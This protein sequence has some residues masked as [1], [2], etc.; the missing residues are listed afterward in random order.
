[1][2]ISSVS[3]HQG[4][5]TAD[6]V[7]VPVW[8]D[9]KKPEI[10]CAVKEFES[11]V[12]FPLSSGDFHGK[13]GECLL[14]YL[15]QGKE[16]RVLLLGLGGKKACLPDTLRRAYASAVKAMRAKKLKSA[17]FLLPEI[18]LIGWEISCQAIIEGVL[19]TSYS[20]D[21]LKGESN[22]EEKHASLERSCFCG[23]DKADHTLLKKTETVIRSV[24]FVRDLV[25]GNADDI[26]VDAFKKIA[27]DFEKEYS[28][29]KTTILDKKG[30]EKEKMGLILAVGRASTREPALI[31][32]EYTGNPHSK[33]KVAII[34]KG[35]TFDTG[36][37]NIK[38]AGTGL[39][40]M[41]CDMA[42]AGV[43]L[44]IIQAAAELKLKVN[45]ISVLPVTENAIGP[46]SYK[47]GDVY[48][49]HSGRTV[50]IS[51]T[52]AEGRLV[53]ADAIS[54]LQD[55]Y[56]PSQ[57]IDFATL[58]GGVIV[59]LGEEATG[60]F[61]NNDAL[62][63]QLEKAGERTHERLWRLP[64]YP[65]YK[66]YLKSSIADIKNSGSRK[67]SAGSGATFIQ[68]FVKKTIPWA[69]LD[70]A[71]TAYLSELKPYHSTPATG[72]GIRLLVDF[73]EHLDVS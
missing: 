28:Q 13:E 69:H 18:D 55:N 3:T 46:A 42:G 19:L 15:P 51:N 44:G 29:V 71:G 1:M 32:L 52:D 8:Q 72:V 25:N 54:Y 66:D 23:L 48:R 57:M 49:S 14:L 33:E 6:V 58:T 26:H 5:K 53:L 50:E 37:L 11:V 4:R 59:A 43:A 40:S 67:A 35:I 62:A 31:I 20:F 38:V 7:V 30:L 56:E 47:P 70:I 34:G 68:Q 64:L 45:L 27:K 16:K 73:L 24:N 10:A 41:K 65:E 39:E 63:K 21:R 12:K 22:E 36:G 2:Q 9:K 17:N 61:S 60:L